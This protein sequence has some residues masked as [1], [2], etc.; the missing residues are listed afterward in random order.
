MPRKYKGKV[1][2]KMTPEQVKKCKEA[3]N[4]L[5]KTAPPSN[6]M[7][8]SIRIALQIIEEWEK[9]TADIKLL[10]LFLSNIRNDVKSLES[11]VQRLREALEKIIK[12]ME[13]VTGKDLLPYS[14]IHHIA[15]SALKT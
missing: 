14:T 6:F 15:S 10:E 1:G 7:M 2:G 12:H 9:M 11:E 4:N 8:D 13:I 5:L 3:L